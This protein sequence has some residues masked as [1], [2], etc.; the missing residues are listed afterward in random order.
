MDK[1]FLCVLP[2][3]HHHSEQWVLD[4]P[5]L[6]YLKHRKPEETFCSPKAFS[7]PSGRFWRKEF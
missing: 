2:F 1:E 5:S 3:V 4:L 7:Q 6:S